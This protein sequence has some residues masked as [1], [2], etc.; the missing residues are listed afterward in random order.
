MLW[1]VV[2]EQAAIR[3]QQE[4]ADFIARSA[5]APTV[6]IDMS[7]GEY[8]R[9]VEIR[10]LLQ[11]VAYSYAANRRHAKPLRYAKRPND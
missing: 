9:E 5:G 7:Y 10:S 11:Q 4:T 1:A 6:C 3:R 2:D 8:M